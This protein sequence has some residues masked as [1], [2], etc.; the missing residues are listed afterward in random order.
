MYL[1]LHLPL[2][3][4]W[5]KCACDVCGYVH[6]QIYGIMKVKMRMEQTTWQKMLPCW[7]AS[8]C[9]PGTRAPNVP[10]VAKVTLCVKQPCRFFWPHVQYTILLTRQDRHTRFCT[11]QFNLLAIEAEPVEDHMQHVFNYQQSE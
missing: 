7:H 10:F 11:L 9:A 1:L 2:H 6:L 4:S 3:V 5:D 8:K